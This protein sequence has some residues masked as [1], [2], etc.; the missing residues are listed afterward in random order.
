MFD[1]AKYCKD[2]VNIFA[3]I[4][5]TE[6]SINHTNLM[7]FLASSTGTFNPAHDK[8]PAFILGVSYHSHPIVYRPE[9]Y[10]ILNIE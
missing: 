7:I 6:V 4:S 9:E 8:N 3:T 1:A 2:Y 10:E 5:A